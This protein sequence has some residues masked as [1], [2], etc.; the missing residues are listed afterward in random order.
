MTGIA[1]RELSPVSFLERAAAVFADRPA[2][3][4]GDRRDTYARLW[5]RAQRLA[6][7]LAA[8]GVQPGDRVAVLSPN[9][10]LLLEAHYG[11]PLAGAVLVALNT[12]PRRR[13]PTSWSTAERA[14]S[15]STPST[16]TRWG[17]S[18][19]R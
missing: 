2:V 5:Q 14:S 15:W 12:R 3:V 18:R 4:D 13:S 7:L 19:S 9:T 16:G 8:R 1:F 6:G 10:H 11:V 17:G